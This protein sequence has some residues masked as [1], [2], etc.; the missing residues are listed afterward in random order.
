MT[1]RILPILV[2][3]AFYTN[4]CTKI[5]TP[6]E[7]HPPVAAF[8]ITPDEGSV[9]TMFR[10]DASGSSDI[11]LNNKLKYRWRFGDSD[12]EWDTD[13]SE[14]PVVV[15]NF[16]KADTIDIILEVIDQ[17]S[18]SS[19]F[20]RKIIVAPS[21]LPD[22]NFTDSRD[23]HTYPY[24]NIGSQTWMTA[25]LAYIPFVGPPE[26]QAGIWVY[27]YGGT[28][29]IGA[30]SREYYQK[31]GCL[32]DWTTATGKNH[33]N[34]RDICPPGWHLPSQEEWKLFEKLI[35]CV[36]I[37]GQY[38]LDYSNDKLRSSFGW[39]TDGFSAYP[40]SGNWF[41][42]SALP[43]G[44]RNYDGIFILEGFWTNYWTSTALDQD[45]AYYRVVG[46]NIQFNSERRILGYSVRCLKDE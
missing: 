27:A 30:A 7:N 22:G 26:V 15:R 21:P 36:E 2:V 25:N 17:D 43:A 16:T 1:S 20:T 28:N 6:G 46:T 37:W 4:S 31:Y 35:G 45:Y 14:E 8:T 18:L 44:Q 12:L 19:R 41:G 34:G 32:Y 40:I 10:L 11:D 3:I 24:K 9:L 5:I 38:R 13:F 39:P 29:P 42:F 33:G 23:G